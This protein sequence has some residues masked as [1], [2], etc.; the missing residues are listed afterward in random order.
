MSSTEFELQKR[1]NSLIQ[2]TFHRANP[3][4]LNSRH[5]IE[6]SVA[7]AQGC[8]PHRTT[9]GRSSSSIVSHPSSGVTPISPIRAYPR[10]IAPTGTLKVRLNTIISS[11]RFA[12]SAQSSANGG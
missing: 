3:K 11:S 6:G 9:F 5:Y 2:R 1:P 10:L 4:T 7:P 8:R 12:G